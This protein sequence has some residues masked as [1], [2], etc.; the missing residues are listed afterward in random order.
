MLGP[1]LR[2]KHVNRSKTL[3]PRIPPYVR[4]RGNSDCQPLQACLSRKARP[5][6]ARETASTS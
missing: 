4:G 1:A 3:H 2:D 6:M 5:S